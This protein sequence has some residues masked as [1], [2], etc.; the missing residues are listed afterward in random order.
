[1][2][3]NKFSNRQ[4]ILYFFV[5]RIFLQFYNLSEEIPFDEKTTTSIEVM[6]AKYIG[7]FALRIFFNDGREKLIDFKPVIEIL[8]P[9][10]VVTELYCFLRAAWDARS[11][12]VL[13]LENNA[14]YRLLNFLPLC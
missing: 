8:T 3:L 13:T 6:K 12:K 4:G 7:D 10:R 14:L 11:A 1:M 5:W 2:K 9:Y